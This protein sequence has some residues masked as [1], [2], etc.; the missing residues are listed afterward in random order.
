MNC[1][2]TIYGRLPIGQLVSLGHFR[3]RKTN[4]RLCDLYFFLL[5]IISMVEAFQALLLSWRDRPRPFPLT[6]QGNAIVLY[7]LFSDK[8]CQLPYQV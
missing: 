1:M 7:D 2:Y 3:I 8:T 5:I 4:G 6:T